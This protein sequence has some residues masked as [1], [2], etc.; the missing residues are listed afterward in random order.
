M[1]KREN[2][3]KIYLNGGNKHTK[4]LN[5]PNLADYKASDYY[6]EIFSIYQELGGIQNEIPFFISKLDYFSNGKIIELDEEN[7]FNR[8][9]E[10]TL[11]ASIYETE[12][13]S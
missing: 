7:H 6:A 11:Q 9:R 2:N 8:Y 5:L 1:G 4:P 3:L 13:N 12:K 10:I